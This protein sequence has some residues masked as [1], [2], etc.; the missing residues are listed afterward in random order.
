MTREIPRREWET[1]LARARLALS[2]Q[3]ANDKTWA[4]ERLGFIEVLEAHPGGDGTAG[5]PATRIR[6]QVPT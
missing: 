5:R 4:M 6:V 1:M 2:R 3:T